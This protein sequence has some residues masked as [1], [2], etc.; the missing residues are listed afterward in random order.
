[1][2]AYNLL[3]S[4]LPLALL[5]RVRDVVFAVTL[6]GGVLLL[7]AILSLVY[8]TVPN[9]RR[10]PWGAIWP[11]AAAA[12]AAI[13][14]VDYAFPLYLSRVSTISHVGTTLVFILIV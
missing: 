7:F 1:M 12:T 10:M 8:W 14:V 11:G 3:L 9:R 6:A 4:I 13:T 2:V 5:A